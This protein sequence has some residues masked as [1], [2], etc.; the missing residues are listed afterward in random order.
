MH[1]SPPFPH[2]ALRAMLLAAAFATAGGAS[3]RDTAVAVTPEQRFQLA[4]E[5]QS[6]RD[7][8]SM[9]SL[10]REAGASGHRE[11]QEMLGVVLL[12]G[13]LL[14][15]NGVPAD[16]CEA[17]H[18]AREAARQGSEVGQHQ[19]HLLNRARNAPMGREACDAQ[20]S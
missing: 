8:R 4:L 19:L 2:R 17:R 5:A 9:M 6:A 3:A 12:A 7:Y 15:G 18:W 1:L 13:P 20:R 10:L 14:Y 11:A 16:R